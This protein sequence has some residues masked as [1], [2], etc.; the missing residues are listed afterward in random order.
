MDLMEYQAKELFAKHDVPVTLGTVVEEPAD[1]RAAAEQ[2]G[3]RVVVKAQ[4]KTGG[5]GKA[6]GVKLA[7]DPDEAVAR[8]AEILGMDIK[9]HQ[10]H[11]VL[12]APTADIAASTTSPTCR[13]RQPALPVHREHPGRR[14]DRDRRAREPRGRRPGSDRP[15]GRGRRREGT[16]DRRSHRLPCRHRRPGSRRGQAAVGGVRRRGRL[17]GGGQPAGPA[18]RRESR[19]ARR[20]GDAR[21]QRRLPA[22][23]PRAFRGPFCD[24]PA[25]GRCQAEGPQLREARWRGRDH[26]QRRR[27]GDVDARRRRVRRRGARR[28]EAG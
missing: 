25:R 15:A 18:R 9:G 10:V 6:G 1:A 27:P 26:R 21:R 17:A 3:G 11:R 22:S 24:R 28:R 8:A 13:P 19:G 14:R 23:R 5:R 4:V 16:R 2:L 12:I 20:Q 7:N